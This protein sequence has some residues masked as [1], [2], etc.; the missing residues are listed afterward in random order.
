MIEKQ[1]STW[2]KAIIIL[3]FMLLFGFLP[4]FGPVTADGMRVLGIFFDFC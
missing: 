3:A 1:K 2:F 4:P